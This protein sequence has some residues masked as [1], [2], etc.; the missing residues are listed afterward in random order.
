MYARKEKVMNVMIF[1]EGKVQKKPNKYVLIIGILQD[2][3]L[4]III[5]NDYYT[6]HIYL[7]YNIEITMFSIIVH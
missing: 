2:G 1:V 3:I 5:T 4:Q 7:E 6:N